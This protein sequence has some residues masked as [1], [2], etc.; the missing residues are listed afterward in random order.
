VTPHLLDLRGLLGAL[1]MLFFAGCGGN[2][3]PPPARLDVL[4]HVY[5]RGATSPT[6][7]LALTI[8]GLG[9]CTPAI[10]DALA[11][12]ATHPRRFVAT[13]FIDPEEWSTIHADEARRPVLTRL[14][15]EGHAVA[16]GPKRVPAAWRENPITMRQGLSAMS[17]SLRGWTGSIGLTPLRAWRPRDTVDFRIIGRAADAERPVILWSLHADHAAHLPRGQTHDALIARLGDRLSAQEIVALPGDERV[18]ADLQCPTARALEAFAAPIQSKGLTPVTIDQLLGPRYARHMPPRLVRYRGAGRPL[19]CPLAALPSVT[20]DG[21]V[22]RWGLVI[23][24]AGDALRVLP[25][26]AD[27][28]TAE[29]IADPAIRAAWRDRAAWQGKPGCLRRVSLTQLETPITVDGP[30]GRVR[31]WTRTAAGVE[32]RDPRFVEAT[33]QAVVLPTR[34]DLVRIEARQRLPWGLRGVVAGALERLGLDA[35]LLL[36]ARAGAG[37][38]FARPVAVGADAATILAALGGVVQIVELTAGEYLFLAQRAARAAGALRTAARAADGFV[39]AGPFLVLPDDGVPDLMR[40]GPNGQAALTGVVELAQ[41]I[42]RSGQSLRPGDVISDGMAA[43]VGPPAAAS[44]PGVFSR[45]ARLRH[46]LARSILEGLSMSAYLRPGAV[47]KVDGDLLGQQT[48][49][50][51]VAPGVSVPSPF[52]KPLVQPRAP[53][54]P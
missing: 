44:P 45:R 9:R 33:G 6:P 48:V 4:Q 32:R 34:A 26:G 12:P 10:L 16:L 23:E 53:R 46:A 3:A 13:F 28:T 25:V 31:W 22:L 47:V 24:R 43:V 29:A 27:R 19:Q 1:G 8:D 7:T 40:V 50:V 21:R 30:N 54:D 41:A 42:L 36:E 5:L 2:P 52:I 15:K 51:A 49:R 14:A 18:D 35:P 17:A 37:V 20:P 39:R 38:V 11:G